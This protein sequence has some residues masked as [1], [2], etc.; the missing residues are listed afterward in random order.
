MVSFK[1]NKRLGIDPKKGKKTY[2]RVGDGS[3]IVAYLVTLPVRIENIEFEAI[4]GFSKSLGIGL[5]TSFDNPIQ[6]SGLHTVNDGIFSKS[7]SVVA[8]FD[9]CSPIRV[10]K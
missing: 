10:A 3:Y 4:I 5:H 6:S 7:V 2:V 1:E 9:R 8:M